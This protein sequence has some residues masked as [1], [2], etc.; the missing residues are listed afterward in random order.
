MIEE[1][2]VSTGLFWYMEKDWWGEGGGGGNAG[3]EGG[4]EEENT[5]QDTEKRG[6]VEKLGGKWRKGKEKECSLILFLFFVFHF[7]SRLSSSSSYHPSSSTSSFSSFCIPHPH[8]QLILLLPSLL[9]FPSSLSL[10]F[11][12]LSPPLPHANCWRQQ[13]DCLDRRRRPVAGHALCMHLVFSCIWICVA[14]GGREEGEKGRC[15]PGD[16]DTSSLST[17]L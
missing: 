2:T 8:L 3:E 7:S 9:L 5:T 10:S 11:L 14:R 15:P 1:G 6:R 13:T 17:P 16:D 4:R 12:L